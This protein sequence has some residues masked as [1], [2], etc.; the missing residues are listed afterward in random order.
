MFDIAILECYDEELEKWCRF[1]LIDAMCGSIETMTK[2]QDES[3]I[4]D[5]PCGRYLYNND[6]NNNIWFYASPPRDHIRIRKSN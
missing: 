5:K 1:E 2:N 6:E 4:P 3:Q